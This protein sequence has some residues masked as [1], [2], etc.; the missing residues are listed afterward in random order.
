MGKILPQIVMV[1]LNFVNL[2]LL[3]F[4][5]NLKENITDTDNLSISN[6]SYLVKSDSGSAMM[7]KF[8]IK[9]D[10]FLNLI[11]ENIECNKIT[12]Y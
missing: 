4:V 3:E 8:L 6:K 1:V 5:Q 2:N 7:I 10:Y 11:N 9:H 12:T